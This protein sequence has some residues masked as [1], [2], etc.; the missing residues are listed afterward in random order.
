[1]EE[2][3]RMLD[4]LIE[5]QLKVQVFKGSEEYLKDEKTLIREINQI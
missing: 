5:T 3:M 2:I 4:L 1:M